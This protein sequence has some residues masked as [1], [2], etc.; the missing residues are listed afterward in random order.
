LSYFLFSFVVEAGL[1]IAFTQFRA[2]PG[3]TT[4]RGFFQEAASLRLTR[5]FQLDL[6][7]ALSG[8]PA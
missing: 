5:E 7:I 4:P 1:L 2:D 6:E 8:G 3:T